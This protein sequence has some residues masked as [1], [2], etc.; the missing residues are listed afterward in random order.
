MDADLLHS[1]LGSATA[2]II[3]RICTHPLDTAKARLQSQSTGEAAKVAQY[4]GPIDVLQKT[5][6]IE[7][8][9]GLYRGFG[10]IVVGGTPGT[11]VY[12]CG[13]EMF[14][15][16]LSRPPP[17]DHQS[18]G[19]SS[20][21]VPE[22]FVHFASG[23]LAETIACIVYVPVDVVKERLQVQQRIHRD[24]HKHSASSR[25][26]TTYRGSYDALRKILRY[27]GLS[28]I[29]K[30]YAAT[31]VSFGPFSAIYFGLYELLKD[32]A[33]KKISA[34][35]QQYASGSFPIMQSLDDAVPTLNEEQKELPFHWLVACSASAG[36]AAS[37][38]TSP[39]DMAKLRLQVQRGRAA[40]TSGSQGGTNL[41]Y[42]GMIDC[43]QY[44]YREGGIKGLFR[45][46]LARVMH[47]TPAT[48]ITMTS[49]EKCRSFYANTLT[50]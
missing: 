3:S 45:G 32:V 16:K 29:Y 38:I 12:L 19:S 49:Y 17:T 48:C 44:A 40:A 34:N 41:A 31:L 22:F 24:N 25:S 2:G 7:G 39:L 9:R 13:Y 10:A 30:G 18:R 14:K 37:W 6:R 50:F 42:R 47:F 4:K 33:R 5:A 23:M 15:K 36:A 46:A 28:G 1:A 11:M 8:I 21:H 43:L 26:S 20:F 35:E 27:E